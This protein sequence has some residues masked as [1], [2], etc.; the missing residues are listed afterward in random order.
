MN[1]KMQEIILEDLII[2]NKF[3]IGNII[4]LIPHISSHFV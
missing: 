4:L 3:S 2:N 1:N